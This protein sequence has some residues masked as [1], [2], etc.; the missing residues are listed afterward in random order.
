MK[1]LFITL[2][3]SF[4]WL[5]VALLWISLVSNIILLMYIVVDGRRA[6]RLRGIIH[7][8]TVKNQ[9]KDDLI[10][11]LSERMFDEIERIQKPNEKL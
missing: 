4:G 1:H 10:E 2:L 6:M 9:Q 11:S 3:F 5:G 7:T 8:L